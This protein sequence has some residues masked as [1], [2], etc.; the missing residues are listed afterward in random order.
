[1]HL[2]YSILEV[3]FNG[4][5][6][7]GWIQE[8]YAWTAV[9]IPFCVTTVVFWRQGVSSAE[10]L[11]VLCGALVNF[12]NSYWSTD[13]Q[14]LSLYS[15]NFF[16]ATLVAL[17]AFEVYRVNAFK[18]AAVSW[19]GLLAADVMHSAIKAFESDSPVEFPEGIGGAGLQDALVLIPGLVLAGTS[20][21]GVL[22]KRRQAVRE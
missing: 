10:W 7:W 15:T 5:N 8:P 1:M 2:A 13:Q 14:A 11:L 17:Y 4:P 18:L 22:R 9:F 20:L 12:L 19:I 16:A 21:L 6:W 3:L